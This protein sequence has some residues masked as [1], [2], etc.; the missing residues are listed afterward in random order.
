MPLAKWREL[1]SSATRVRLRAKLWLLLYK[2][3]VS[4]KEDESWLTDCL[5]VHL[6]DMKGM[7]STHQ[8]QVTVQVTSNKNILYKGKIKEKH[9]PY[10]CSSKGC[11]EPLWVLA[12]DCRPPPTSLPPDVV[13][14]TKRY[15]EIERETKNCE[16]FSRS[17]RT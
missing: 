9:D 3:Y 14:G 6:D 15:Q 13:T 5:S 2:D 10:L 7:Q 11:S 17:G 1:P 16:V 4:L 12:A 8:Q